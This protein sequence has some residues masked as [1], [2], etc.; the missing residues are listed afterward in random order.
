MNG[1]A[2]CG[3]AEREIELDSGH[4]YRCE[5]GLGILTKIV[6]CWLVNLLMGN[7]QEE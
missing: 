4:Y 1:L 5:V 7:E 6:S 2:A 3:G